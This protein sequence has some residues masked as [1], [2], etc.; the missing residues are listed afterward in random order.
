VSSIASANSNIGFSASTGAV[1]ATLGNSGV[2]AGINLY[3]NNSNELIGFVGTGGSTYLGNSS[4]PIIAQN[5][6][7]PYSVNAFN[8]GALHDPW[9]ILYVNSLGTSG[10]YIAN[11]YVTTLNLNGNLTTNITGSTQCVQANSAG[12]LSGTGSACGSG[13]GGGVTTI[14]SANANLSFNSSTG[15]VVATINPN[16]LINSITISGTGISTSGGNLIGG[17]G[18]TFVGNGAGVTSAGPLLPGST[19]T[20]NLGAA[21]YIW[22]AIYADTYYAGTSATP[23]VSCAAGSVNLV[24]FTVTDGIV[25]HC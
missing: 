16:L 9:N 7:E 1:T 5:T 6:I 4:S 3:D 10:E 15:N 21:S 8:L 19:N 22:S 2:V 20:Y 23:G 24:T 18:V 12:V 25:T 14:S 17:T 11:G 13:S